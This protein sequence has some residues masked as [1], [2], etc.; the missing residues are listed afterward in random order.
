MPYIYVNPQTGGSDGSDYVL[1]TAS[2]VTKGGVKIGEG[3]TMTGEVLSADAQPVEVMTGATQSD[4]G[5]SGTVPAPQ[6][7]DQAKY[8][9]GDGQWDTPAAR[10]GTG[11]YAVV[12]GDSGNTATGTYAHAEGESCDATGLG[13]HSEGTGTTASSFGSHAEG[14]GTIS[15]NAGA[16]A[17]GMTT[18]ASNSAAHAEGKGTA[19][20]G[21]AAHAEGISTAA[22]GDASR[23]AGAYTT[24]NKYAQ[25]TFGTYNLVE[26][27]SSISSTIPY[28]EFSISNEVT[29]DNGETTISYTQTWREET[30]QISGEND[31][32]TE[33]YMSF[34]VPGAKSTDLIRVESVTPAF[35]ASTILRSTDNQLELNASEDYGYPFTITGKLYHTGKHSGSV[36]IPA[37]ATSVNLTGGSF[38]GEY[39]EIVGNGTDENNRSNARTLDWSGNETIA[40]QMTAMQFNGSG[41]GLTDI[42]SSAL[43]V[44]SNSALGAVKVG[45][46]LS[47]NSETGVLSASDKLVAVSKSSSSTAM[48]LMAVSTPMSLIISTDSYSAFVASNAAN[49]PTIKFSTGELAAKSFSGSGASLTDLNGSNISS[50]TVAAARIASLP[51]SKITSGT[52]ASARIP[53]A[54]ASAIGGIKVGENLSIDANGVLSADAQSVDVMTGAGQN[55]DGASGLVPAPEAGDQGKYLRGD[56]TWASVSSDQ[57]TIPTA[58]AS[59]LGGVRIGAGLT[60]TGEVLSTDVMTGA[61][62]TNPGTAGTVP[63]PAATDN[64]SF[65]QGDATW[66]KLNIRNGTGTDSV[67][68][69][70][71][72]YASGNYSHAEG[73]G[74]SASEAT[75]HAEG[76]LT[77]AQRGYSHAE[78]Y[79]TI[80]DG[81]GSHVEGYFTKATHKSQHVFGEYN[82]YDPSEA[83]ATQRGTYVEIVGNGTSTSDSGR[84]NA[85]TLDWNGNE[86]LAGSCTA[87]QFNGSGAG[88][89]NIPASSLPTASDSALGAVKIGSGLSIDSTT[90]VLSADVQSVDVMTGA[91]AASKDGTSGLV[92]APTKAQADCF[93]KGDGTWSYDSCVKVSTSNTS[94]TFPLLASSVAKSNLTSGKFVEAIYP[95]TADNVPTI[96][97]ST[98]KLTAASFSGSGASLTSLNASNLSSG[99]VPAARLPDAST[100]AKGAMSAADKAKLDAF[101]DASTYALK[102]DITAMYKHKGS[103]ATTNDLPSTNNTEGDVY[104]VAETGMNYVWVEDNGTG[105]WDALG[106]IMSVISITNAEIDTILAS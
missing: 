48:P 102:S 50:G 38:K 5:A 36:Y 62:G 73:W 17:E 27:V 11:R 55:E 34:S 67:V 84:S 13:S 54:S 6:A 82:D 75:A 104:N 29:V 2:A 105:S 76:Y 46:G 71:N 10:H 97:P 101:G 40:G 64:T 44:A 43:P 28:T 33:Y 92:P 57:V 4:P 12:E 66:Y 51:A 65:L 98:G 99:T 9:Q 26:N 52:F 63:S 58:S 37:N 88:L 25:S 3:L 94:N 100:S 61:D 16:H 78:G 49:Q 32:W 35:D 95:S 19:A 72:T 60:M 79:R 31:S 53:V 106:S 68:Q 15:S 21:E 18:I 89:T 22:S 20:G 83:A 87:T 90:G 85:R 103:V 30:I 91:V 81:S 47:I 56:G 80:A 74:S 77:S 42:P 96:N 59:V 86:V 8:L 45:S 24:A 41:A 69:G 1:P 70:T 7:G 93:L 39:V 23:S 14:W